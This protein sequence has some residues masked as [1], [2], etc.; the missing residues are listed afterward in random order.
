MPHKACID[1]PGTL[2]HIILRGIERAVIFRDDA[3]G[4]NFP[5]RVGLL[6]SKPPSPDGV[7]MT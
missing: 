4:E 1:A 7:F 6:C 2:H 5:T 3:D